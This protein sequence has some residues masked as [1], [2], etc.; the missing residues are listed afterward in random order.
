MQDLAVVVRVGKTGSSS[1]YQLLLSAAASQS[2]AGG[3]EWLCWPN[4]FG[5]RHA[6]ACPA[7][8]EVAIGGAPVYGSGDVARGATAWRRGLRMLTTLREPAMRTVSEFGYFCLACGDENKFCGR[9]NDQCLRNRTN[10]TEWVVRAPNQYVR[11]FSR[12]WPAQSFLHEYVHGSST[13][14]TMQDVDRATQVLTRNTSRV[15]HVDDPKPAAQLERLRL[16]L[17]GGVPNR[18]R[19]ARALAGVHGFPHEN[20]APLAAQYAPTPMERALVCATNW[21]DCLLWERLGRG[22]CVC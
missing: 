6:A 18:S 11:Q 16:W 8:S 1:L 14:V 19:A 7:H 10:F 2:H 3:V 22:R 9:I 13:P 17:D 4:R 20:A 12:F 15:L 5:T 21:A